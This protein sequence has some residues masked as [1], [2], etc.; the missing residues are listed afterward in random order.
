MIINSEVKC[1][2]WSV[3][4]GEAHWR[5]YSLPVVTGGEE[6]QECG[7]IARACIVDWKVY[8]G[9]LKIKKQTKYT[10]S[11]QNKNLSGKIELTNTNYEKTEVLSEFLASVFTIE[12]EGEIPKLKENILC[13]KIMDLDISITDVYKKTY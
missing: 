6:S 7:W 5:L 1:F 8:P 2:F 11:S 9:I 4:D 12:P 10:W 13:K 3:E